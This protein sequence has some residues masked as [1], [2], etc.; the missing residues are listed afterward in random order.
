M[1]LEKNP[2]LKPADIKAILRRT[3]RN[4]SVGHANPSSSDNNVGMP[5]NTGD[6][7]ACGAGLVDAFAAFQQV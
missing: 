7:G 2:G 1:L 4:V 5:A 6:N 3:A